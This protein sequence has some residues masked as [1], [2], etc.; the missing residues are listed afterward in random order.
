[1]DSSYGEIRKT[2]PLEISLENIATTGEY[3]KHFV[4]HISIPFAKHK[5]NLTI[6]EK[7]LKDSA[8]W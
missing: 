6:Q 7:H 8:K 4:E 1:M 5:R 3:L 2:D